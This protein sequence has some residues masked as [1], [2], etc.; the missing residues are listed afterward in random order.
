T[1]VVFT[2]GAF[3]GCSRSSLDTSEGLRDIMSTVMLGGIKWGTVTFFIGTIISAFTAAFAVMER[4]TEK[5]NLLRKITYFKSHKEREVE[6]L[7]RESEKRIKTIGENF[8]ERVTDH[9]RTVD[10]IRDEKEG[11]S[12]ELLEE[13]NKKIDSYKERLDVV[14][15]VEG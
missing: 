10:R 7:T 12:A 1:L 14:V 9:K 2:I 13:A 3:T 4:T 8:N 6:L 11:R 15:K 5:Q